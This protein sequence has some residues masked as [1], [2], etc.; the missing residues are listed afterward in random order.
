[1]R[2]K[3]FFLIFEL[4]LALLL[5]FSVGNSISSPQRTNSFSVLERVCWDTVNLWVLGENDLSSLSLYLAA[6]GKIQFSSVSF[7]SVS[8]SN[9]FICSGERFRAGKWESLFVRVEV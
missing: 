6:P 8:A 2:V 1:M 4:V 3:G 9:A 5:F 7:S